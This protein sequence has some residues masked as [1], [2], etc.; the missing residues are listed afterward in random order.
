LLI[1]LISTEY[2]ETSVW[3]P[4]RASTI[5]A[6]PGAYHVRGNFIDPGTYTI[7]VALYSVDGRISDP[8]PIDQF[9]LEITV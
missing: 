8:V 3:G 9:Q 4:D 6:T 2:N 5:H 7:T 1:E